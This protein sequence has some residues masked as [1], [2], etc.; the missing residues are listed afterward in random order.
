MLIINFIFYK[1]YYLAKT[2]DTETYWM[3]TIILYIHIFLAVLSVFYKHFYKYLIVSITYKRKDGEEK[4]HQCN[5]VVCCFQLADNSSGG[6]HRC[7]PAY[8]TQH[9]GRSAH[10]GCDCLDLRRFLLLIC[11]FCIFQIGCWWDKK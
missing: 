6:F 1:F 8:S 11:W 3:S 2:S 10:H 4:K 9:G 5:C 7:R